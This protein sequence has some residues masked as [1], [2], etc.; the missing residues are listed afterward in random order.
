MTEAL[1]ASPVRWTPSATGSNPAHLLG[2]RRPLS[3]R[4]T[5]RQAP[6][7]MPTAAIPR[8]ADLASGSTPKARA[9]TRLSAESREDLGGESVGG[10]AATQQGA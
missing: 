5:D 10:A 3:A 2:V 8:R 4:R 6:F 7:S 9:L 1:G